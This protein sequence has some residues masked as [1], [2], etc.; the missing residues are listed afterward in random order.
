[1]RDLF[2]QFLNFFQKTVLNPKFQVETFNFYFM[3]P[4]KKFWSNGLIPI[5]YSVCR[6]RTNTRFLV[7]STQDK[8]FN[9]ELLI[10]LS[11][12]ISYDNAHEFLI[13]GS[14]TFAS[15]SIHSTFKRS[16]GRFF[17]FL[18]DNCVR[19]SRLRLWN[20]FRFKF[21][22]FSWD[23]SNP[24][25]QKMIKE[26][27]GWSSPGPDNKV[28]YKKSVTMRAKAFTRKSWRIKVR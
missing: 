25:R 24:H 11:S 16:A 4:T 3:G 28:D 10:K 17:L 12:K 6:A 22:F 26:V 5:G 14:C 18:L 13:C 9:S 7:E 20:I 19:F 1:M 8:S 2:S 27:L 15:V 23:I 21:R